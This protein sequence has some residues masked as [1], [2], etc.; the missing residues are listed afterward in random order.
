MLGT[1][2]VRAVRARKSG[3]RTKD[4]ASALGISP[5]TVS[6]WIGEYKRGGARSLRSKKSSGRPRKIDCSE[7]IPKL[8]KIIRS[9]ATKYGFSNSLWN[10]RRLRTVIR[11]ELG[12]KVSKTTVWRALRDIGLSYQKPERQAFEADDD[13]REEWITKEWPKIRK[14]AA[15]QRAVVLFQDEST[16]SLSPTLGKTWAKIAHT[17]VV[18]LTGNRGSICVISAISITGKLLFKIPK[19]TVNSAEFIKFLKQILKEIP[20]KIIYMIVDNGPSHKSKMTKEFVESEPRLK[21]IF[22]PSYSPDFNPDEYTW[23]RLKEVELKAHM[24]RTKSG[25]KRKTL[26]AM[27]SIQKK[28]RLVQSFFKRSKLT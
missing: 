9:S 21:L 27:R 3:M 6:R 12:L 24:E 4:I 15:G 1:A 13:L 18:K 2:R 17:P 28:P 20:R 14:K 11:T 5:I 8:A 10:S 25:L 23:A 16:L 7:F 26:G 22:L 19:K